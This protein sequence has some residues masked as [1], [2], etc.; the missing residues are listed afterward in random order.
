[1]CK[2]EDSYSTWQLITSGVPQVSILGPLLFIAFIND[3]P[4]C[5]SSSVFLFADDSKALIID[6]CIL[7]SDF[8]AWAKK[9]SM[10]FNGSK[11]ELLIICGMSNNTKNLKFND[12]AHSPVPL[13]KDLGLKINHNLKW[14]K[15]ISKGISF[16]YSLF[17]SLRRNLPSS[18]LSSFKLCLF[19]S[20][21]LS[22]IVYASEVWLPSTSDLQKLKMLQKNCCI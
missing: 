12:I 5:I 20:Y 15:H 9:N 6:P 14:D 8:D 2:V 4:L 18:L 17:I 7:Q 1:M 11:S 22:S 19:K 10:E 13:V 3:F 16:C 21:I